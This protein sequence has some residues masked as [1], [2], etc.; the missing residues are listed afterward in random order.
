MP[1]ENKNTT[2]MTNGMG[3]R[4][5]GNA[6]HDTNRS[7]AGVAGPNGSSTADEPYFAHT[8]MHDRSAHVSRLSSQINRT[9]EILKT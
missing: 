4:P 9:D 2:R 8:R 5:N 1:S 7:N 6:N 3:N